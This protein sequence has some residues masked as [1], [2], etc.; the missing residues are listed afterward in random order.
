MSRTRLTP[1]RQVDPAVVAGH[2]EQTTFAEHLQRCADNF[3]DSDALVEGEHRLTYGALRDQ[4][5]AAAAGLRALGL[6]RHGVLTVELPNWWE[7]AIIAHATLRGGSV[8][9]PVTP[10][11][12]KAEVSFVMDQAQTQ[13][14]VIPHIYRG[15]DYVQ[16]MADLVATMDTPPAVV[17]VRPQGE[18]PAGFTAFE[19]LLRYDPMPREGDPE[20]ICLLLYTSGT[21]SSPKGV[22][23]SHQTLLHEIRSI[24]GLMGLEDQARM[25]MASPVG[26]L[27]GVVYGTLLPTVYGQ[28][29]VY[30]PEWD[31]E[32]AVD[33]IEREGCT[34]SCGATPF[35]RGL[36]DEYVR[37]GTSSSLEVF[38]CGGADIP[39]DLAI[40]AQKVLGAW[41]SRT[42]G[43]SEC[44]ILSAT[45][46]QDAHPELAVRT[47]G[48]PIPPGEVKLLD[49]V[50]GIGEVVAR[51]PD[52]F[53]GYLDAS[54]NEEA[55]TEDGFFKM[56]DLATL[57]EH[58]AISV[59]GR[60]KDIIIRNGENISAREVEE[61]ILADPL[62][63][64][65]AVLPV[66]H[67]ATG[68]K[69]AAY[70]VLA[71]GSTY[72]L[73]D[74]T[75]HLNTRGLAKQKYPEYL[76]VI[77]V[78]PSTPSGKV[79]K[80]HLRERATIDFGL[81]QSADTRG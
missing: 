18:L 16:M 62:I 28:P 20:D 36:H 27:T 29:A 70:V 42:Y 49:A 58:G 43:S 2:W 9:N 72:T 5:A 53:L 1:T 80:F 65:V 51:A 67:P 22:L 10:I 32:V 50:D 66:P 24:V 45:G 61:H 44:P 46:P 63:S 6:T 30:L 39:A 41:V 57:D 4:S 21:T 48:R 19:D 64:E 56:G 69:A 12:R 76:A 54:L 7:F 37:R 8:L 40:S 79:Q 47:D 17:V 52:L 68:E 75:R 74:L 23:H 60:K 31:P 15:F 3:P 13:V 14:M 38:L 71:E 11:F 35:M 33:I 55:F 77:D 26:H 78:L 34:I 59:V 25:F 73:E 81:G